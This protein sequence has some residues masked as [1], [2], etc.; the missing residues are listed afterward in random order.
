MITGD[1]DIIALEI[2]VNDG[3]LPRVEEHEAFENLTT[4]TLQNFDVDLLEAPKIRLQRARCHQLR[5]EYKK[6]SFL[7]VNFPTVEKPDNVRMLKSFQHFGLFSKS[8]SFR[9]VQP[10]LQFAPGHGYSSRGI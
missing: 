4:P 5:D 2:S 10:F 9:F 6:L 1:E 3:R 8:L 7:S